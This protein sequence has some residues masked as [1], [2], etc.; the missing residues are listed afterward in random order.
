MYIKPIAS[1]IH[2][3]QFRDW[4][5]TGI[6]FEFE[7]APY[8]SS[9]P[10][11]PVRSLVDTID[12]DITSGP[13][14]SIGVDCDRSNELANDL[15]QVHYKGTGLEQHRYT[16]TDIALYNV[17]SFIYEITTGNKYSMTIEGDVFSGLDNEKSINVNVSDWN[18][19]KK[20]SFTI[21][22]LHGF[23]SVL[24]K[25]RLKNHFFDSVFVSNK[26]TSSLEHEYLYEL[27]SHDA[28]LFV[29]TCRFDLAKNE[30]FKTKSIAKIREQLL[31]VNARELPNEGAMDDLLIFR[32]TT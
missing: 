29:E 4:R 20:H 19:P 7:G 3:I 14:Y 30:S 13:F 12:I 26:C 9:N 18:S 2:P 23:Q 22:P 1:I 11:I 8:T 16:S 10:T 31:R 27:L 17:T 5:L 32:I 21:V 15:F 6:A 28:T 24:R 25:Q